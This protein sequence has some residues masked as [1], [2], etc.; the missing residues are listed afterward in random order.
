[1]RHN[2]STWTG[3][4]AVLVRLHTVQ[5]KKTATAQTLKA[6]GDSQ[7]VFEEQVKTRWKGV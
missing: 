7:G 5:R 4:G 3:A 2:S 1:M 6:D